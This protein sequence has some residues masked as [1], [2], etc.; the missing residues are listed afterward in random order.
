MWRGEGG[1]GVGEGGGVSV[2]ETLLGKEEG[3]KIG[4]IKE[5]RMYIFSFTW[6][7]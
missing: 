5:H 2:V 6:W 4:E 3:T 1:G 7:F